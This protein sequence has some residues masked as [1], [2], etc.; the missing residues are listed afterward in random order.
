MHVRD[1]DDPAMR[2][3]QPRTVESP[4]QNAS[5]T[6]TEKLWTSQ[7]SV[8][9]VLL[10]QFFPSLGTTCTTTLMLLFKFAFYFKLI[11]VLY[12]LVSLYL[13]FYLLILI[14][15]IMSL[16]SYLY[17]SNRIKIDT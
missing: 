16:K 12:F 14:L 3:G 13:L 11:F 15:A 8:I 6:L 1:A 2:G 9:W 7:T 10:V 4:A 5:G 17:F